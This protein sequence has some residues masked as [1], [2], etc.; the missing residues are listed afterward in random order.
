MLEEGYLAHAKNLCSASYEELRQE[1][2]ICEE[3]V[4]VESQKMKRNYMNSAEEYRV[5]KK[6]AMHNIALLE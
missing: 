4:V 1:I 3:G 2:A 6:V 5:I